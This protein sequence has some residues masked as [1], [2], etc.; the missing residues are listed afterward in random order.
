[1]TVHRYFEDDEE[2]N[3]EDLEYLPAPDSPVLHK[4]SGGRNGSDSDGSDDP[5]DAFMADIAVYIQ[6]M[7]K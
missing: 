5:L 4:D 1:M 6:Q 7:S 2:T 3:A